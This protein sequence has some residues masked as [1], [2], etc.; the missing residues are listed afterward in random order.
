VK[1]GNNP[2][3]TTGTTGGPSCAVVTPKVADVE[4]KKD[5]IPDSVDIGEQIRYTLTVTNHGPDE[6]ANVVVTDVLDEDVTFVGFVTDG[7]VNP[8]PSGACSHAAGTITCNLGALDDEEVMTIAYD[9]TADGPAGEVTNT[10]SVSTSSN[11]I[12]S[13][14]NSDTETTE[15]KPEP[16]PTPTPTETEDPEADLTITKSDS[17]D[18]VFTNGTLTYTLVVTNNG[19]DAAE[20]VVVT[21]PLP[22][23]TTLDS[24]GYGTPAGCGIATTPGTVTCNLGT[25]DDDETV[26]ITFNVTAPDFEA[27]L[28]NTASVTTTTLEFNTDDNQDTETTNVIEPPDDDP[29]VDLEITKSDSADPFTLG[30]GTLTY[31]LVVSNNGPDTA[32]FVI[33][34]DGLPDDVAF[35]D[36]DNEGCSYN[37][38]AHEVVCFLGSMA[39]GAT[40]TI[41]IETLPL[42]LGLQ[43]NT[44]NVDLFCIDFS[45]PGEGF[46][47]P[48]F[49]GEG[50]PFPEFPG[51]EFPF[52]F[53][54][55]AEDSNPA[56]NNDTETTLVTAP[57]IPPNDPLADLSIDKTDSADPVNVGD[58]F[59]YTLSV[60]NHGPNTANSVIV[61]DLLPSGT[62][63]VSAASTTPG[64]TCDS[65]V[66]ASGTDVITCRLATLASGAGFDVS[67]V[68]TADAVGAV[69][70]TASATSA[71]PD[72]DPTDNTDSEGTVI[73]EPVGD[74]GTIVVQKQTLPD[75]AAN[76]FAFDGAIVADLGDDQSASLEVDPG[77][78][79]VTEQHSDGWTLTRI[80][81]IDSDDSGTAS[82]GSVAL[83]TAAFNVEAGETVTCVF[84][85]VEDEVLGGGTGPPGPD[86]PDGPV[87]DD[88]AER[89]STRGSRVLPFTGWTGEGLPQLAIVMIL[90]GL[91]VLGGVRMRRRARG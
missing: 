59:T 19:P 66:G 48:E 85:N 53:F 63:F 52:P 7:Q 87:G 36:L 45:F 88:P 62:S 54:C 77:S 14:N 30:S 44:A 76:V 34:S 50:F 58:E 12:V 29:T 21:D 71:T 47:F 26:T 32:P 2:D 64:V 4:I 13:S 5:D 15:V 43:T 9:V 16:T 40:Q 25:L 28:T 8:A 61:T 81:C 57:F 84:T 24:Y 18:P 22:P 91:A 80:Q 72:P 42:Q 20:N 35:L 90:L 33:V 56:N 41:T 37:S 39:S 27:T 6:A 73:G 17:P 67:V 68:V 70:N 55:D 3:E 23:G 86:G 38:E 11:D 10:A 89:P 46:P 60:F 83:A 82:N 1:K 65:A 49:P 79:A 31:T 69:V 74:K 51:G 78:Y 75:G